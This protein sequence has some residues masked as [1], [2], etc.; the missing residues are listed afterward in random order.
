M[1]SH[2]HGAAGGRARGARARRERSRA[3]RPA[4]VGGDRCAR[5]A[6]AWTARRARPLRAHRART[7]PCSRA[8][9]GAR[10]GAR[11]GARA[12][13]RRGGG[14]RAR[15]RARRLRRRA[16]GRGPR[17]PRGDRAARGRGGALRGALALARSAARAARPARAERRAARAARGSGRARA[18]VSRDA[19]GGRRARDR[20]IRRHARRCGGARRSRRR[21][22]RAARAPAQP[23]PRQRAR[24]A[25]A[26]RNGGDALRARR[27]PR[28]CRD[29]APDSR[30]GA[31]RDPVRP[32]RGAPAR[33]RRLRSV[34]RRGAA[35]RGHSRALRARR[36]A[37][38]SERAR[39]A[40]AARVRGRE[41]LVRAPGGDP[42]AAPAPG[43]RWVPPDEEL[44]APSVAAAAEPESERGAEPDP[45]RGSGSL[46]APR[47]W[48][49][50]LVEAAVIGGRDR[51]RRRIDGYV[52][53]LEKKIAELDEPDGAIAERLRRDRADVAHLSA[54]ALPLIDELAKL[55]T[56]A[57]WG[58]WTLALG[59]L[60]SRV[61]RSPERVQSVLAELA[62]MADVGPIGLREVQLVLAPR[63][64]Q[65]ASPP[66]GARY[67]KVF[68]APVEA[69]RG[70]DFDAVFVPGLAE[71]LFPRKIG[72]EPI[73][74]DAV[75]AQLDAGLTTNEQRLDAERLALRLAVGAGCSRA[76]L[77]FPRLDVDGSRPRVP[78]FYALEAL[79]AAEGVLPGFDELSRRAETFGQARLGWPAPARAADAIDAA[80]FDLARLAALEGDDEASRGAARYLLG[81]NP[82]L[83]R[84]LRFRGRRWEVPGWTTAD[85]FVKPIDAGRRA[86]AAHALGARSYSPTAL[87][88][89]ASCPYKFFL[90]AVWKLAPR[91]EPEAIEEL[92]PLQRGSLVHAVQFELFGALRDAG[93]LPVTPARLAAAWEHLDGVLEKVA[94]RFADDL[95]PAIDRVWRDG[96]QSV[97]ADLR[98]WLRRASEDDSGFVPWRF[99]LSFGLPSDRDADPASQP[100]PVPLDAGLLR[101]R[102]KSSRLAAARH[103]PQDRQGALRGG[104]RDRRRAHAPAGALRARGR[105]AVPGRDRRLGPAL[106]LH[107]CGRLRGAHGA[108]RRRGAR[109][110]GR[111]DEG[112]ARGARRA[113][114]ARRARRGRVPLV[115]LPPGV[116]SVRGAARL[117]QAPARA[118]RAARAAGAAVSALPIDA[119]ARRRIAEHLDT[120]LFV[121]AAA[122]T[123]KTTALVGRIVALLRSGRATLDR[124]VALTFADK[125]AGEMR[126][127]LRGELETARAQADAGSAE[128][129][130][131]DA[132]LEQ[133][134]LARI[135]TIHAF[136]GDLLQERPVEAGVDPLFAIA[137]P[138]EAER[139]LERAFDDWFQAALGDPP[140]GVRRLLRR[141]PRGP[142]A[143]SGRATLLAAARSLAEHRDYT[144]RW[145]RDPFERERAIAEVMHE[146]EGLAELAE[147][148]AD[149]SD[150]LPQNLANIAR[151]VA[152]NRL[153]EAVRE[154]DYDALEAELRDLAKTRKIGWH[155]MGRNRRDYGE[156]LL[157]AEVL[158]R[159]DAAKQ[160]L[161]LLLADCDADL[162][163]CLQP[164]LLPVVA[165]YEGHK[166]AA[167]VLDFVDLLVCARDLLVRDP[168][169]RAD[170]ARR[171]THYF[172]D[173]FQDTD[174]LQAE[175]LMLLVSGDPEQRDWRAAVPAPGRLFV[176]GDPKQSIYRFR[177]A[178]VAIYEQIKEHLVAHGA[179]PVLLR[180]SFRSVPAIQEAVNAAFAPEMQA[181]ADRSQPRYVAL[182]PVR[183]D[184]PGQPA[185]VV[186]P[187]P[188]PWGDY[189]TVVSWKVEDS[190]PDAVGAFV[191]WLIRE[192]GWTVEE[193]GERVPVDSRHVCLLFR[194]FRHF[195]DDATR[196]YQRAL[197]ARHVPHVLVGGRSFHDREE[198]IALRNALT[199]IEWPGDELSVY[200]ALRGPLFALT[201][202]L[203]LAW[204][205]ARG[206]IHP[207]AP[208]DAADLAP[209]LREVGNALDVLAR[210]HR[211]RNRR[212]IA[213][214]VGQLLEAVRA[215]AALAIW[216]TGEQA[217]ANCLRV[218]DLARRFERAGA[219]SFR[220]FVDRLEEDAEGGDTEDA[221]VVEEGTEGVRIM[222]AHRAK[223]LEFPAVVLCDP[224]A[225]ATRE[226]P[227]RHVDPERSLWA[228]P[229]AGCAPRELLEASAVELARDRAE[230]VRLAYVA[231]TRARD[232]LV[233]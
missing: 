122:G 154:R 185:L 18:R 140:E 119:D 98:E 88:H 219:S 44:V 210:L 33:A 159:R 57:R 14:A 19:A 197:E 12:G 24:A 32:H 16:R 116:R 17:R 107:F 61:L 81:A 72:E 161:D 79:R 50:L 127:R 84:A 94:A 186:V 47:R 162:A 22:D 178:D 145:R 28:M 157:R 78:S 151:F 217:L 80:E 231:A 199:A 204:R 150:W 196:P 6:R 89:Y 121:E 120:T 183:A 171:F 141:R 1:A 59:A 100:D 200:A 228:E 225:N 53:E 74:L 142:D 165:K 144:A 190:L 55:P 42:P 222:T 211:G 156:G 224:T 34:P 90:Q 143:R 25:R 209:E 40:R 132:A 109:C 138:D 63:L 113:V 223:G 174:P 96:V 52:Q 83:A 77:S 134:E 213:D 65:T 39:A 8:G 126:L 68:V 101:R 5:A 172:V 155:Y 15:A 93:L 202:D 221:P 115:R 192:S 13:E 35:P 152:E 129:A 153:R 148:A 208:R 173:E 10:G 21:A 189:G 85:G 176:V 51:W 124:I 133:L 182:E 27:E 128:R 203:L 54:F 123:G 136:C 147:R 137:A 135:A 30:R 169:V 49:R 9:L 179:E 45:A 69:V 187:A 227:G 218:M 99:E 191:A 60:A 184:A 70:L 118:R 166:R 75:R 64:L 23:V 73:L 66:P 180:A 20:R 110:G 205:A 207:L 108:A 2:H 164:E 95:A 125:A 181:A 56:A 216:P 76:A 111:G 97:R 31:R 86:L 212:P 194:R 177:R 139:L 230:A 170:L 206:T 226:Q 149:P 232:L 102:A 201:D 43:D 214:T 11:R 233:V 188:R 82:H 26:R 106:L 36:A 158:A 131:L 167:G 195:R 37:P 105:E 4:R 92:D 67:G 104:R 38:R 220:A 103:G 87:Q 7:G 71:K 62:P 29:R 168:A 91:E 3:G 193:R 112:A 198:V 163:A 46:P 48:E 114:P 229:L 130:R 41:L 117:A 58:E 146:L 160:H 215:H 175:I